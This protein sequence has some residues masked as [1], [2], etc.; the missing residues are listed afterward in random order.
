[1]G[2]ILQKEQT[3]ILD[4]EEKSDPIDTLQSSYFDHLVSSNNID[5]LKAFF[6]DPADI[7]TFTGSF[8]KSDA[9]LSIIPKQEQPTSFHTQGSRKVLALVTTDGKETILNFKKFVELVKLNN[10]RF[11]LTEQMNLFLGDLFKGKH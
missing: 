11:K 5:D 10:A 1:M 8:R 3:F 9:T 7:R 4:S 2:A 6:K